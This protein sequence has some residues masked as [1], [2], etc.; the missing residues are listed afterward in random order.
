MEI[1]RE[2]VASAFGLSGAELAQIRM[3]KHVAIPRQIAM[4][5]LKQ[6]TEASMVEIAQ[7]FGNI[8]RPYCILSRKWSNNAG[9]APTSN[10]WSINYCVTLR[11]RDD[12][13]VWQRRTGGRPR[14]LWQVPSGRATTRIRSLCDVFQS[15]PA[16][17][18]L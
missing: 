1:I 5:L 7:A 16:F 17:Q 14:S 10:R 9:L 8:T 15:G 6:L 12:A 3:A 2:T 18:T 4:Y 11:F 13:R